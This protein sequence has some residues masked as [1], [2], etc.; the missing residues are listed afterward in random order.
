MYRTKV[1]EVVGTDLGSDRE[2]VGRDC[3]RKSNFVD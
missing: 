2:N 3:A 1:Q